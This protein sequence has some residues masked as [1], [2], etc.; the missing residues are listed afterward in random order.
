MAA[1][2]TTELNITDGSVMRDGIKVAARGCAP[3]FVVV[4]GAEFCEITNDGRCVH[5]GVA[6]YGDNESCVVSAAVPL[7]LVSEEFNTEANFD[8]LTVKGV[9]Y[10]GAG[11]QAGP[12]GISMAAGDTIEWNS[13]GSV[14]RDGFKVCGSN[15]A[16]DCGF[17]ICTQEATQGLA[18][19]GD[20]VRD[21]KK[22]KRTVK[23]TKVSFARVVHHENERAPSTSRCVVSGCQLTLLCLLLFCLTRPGSTK[24]LTS[25]QFSPRAPVNVR[26][27]LVDSHCQTGCENAFF[28]EGGNRMYSSQPLVLTPSFSNSVD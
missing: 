10:H 18:R 28:L 13:D 6:G 25:L 21:V 16:T 9:E 27:E 22:C 26:S 23:A 1:G 12:N 8:K 7:T 14:T 2:D 4:S 11:T 3:T 17:S 5:D 19:M 15:L 20:S 24:W